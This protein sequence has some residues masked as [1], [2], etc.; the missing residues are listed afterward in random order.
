MQ[1]IRTRNSATARRVLGPSIAAAVLALAA[2]AFAQTD[3]M[4]PLPEL[5]SVGGPAV[6][7]PLDRAPMSSQDVQTLP[8]E[9]RS[10]PATSETTTTTVGEDGVETVTRTRRIT[11]SA[12]EQAG[13]TQYQT[14]EQS[15]YGYA[16]VQYAPVQYAPIAYAPAPA[17][18]DRASWL[19]ECR[20]RTEGLSRKERAGVIGGLIGAIGGGI[21]GNRIAGGNRLA[22]TLIGAG[23]GGLA[24]VATGNAVADG[25][26]RD[27]YDCEDVL[28]GYLAQPSAIPVQAAPARIASRTIPAPGY[29]YQGYAPPAYASAYSYAPAH[30]YGY[31]QPPQTVLVPVQTMQQQRVIVRET[32]R[33]EMVPAARS[34]PRPVAEPFPVRQVAPSPKMIKN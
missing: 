12:P 13:P 18:F 6:V 27:R 33:E 30:S 20:R 14:G 23:V 4:P 29:A 3:E 22:G 1:P 28:E 8:P 25:R 21:I 31:V 17:V 5:P 19:A 32:V 24:G 26:D 16:P 9:Y 2:P 7:Q 34:I 15:T 11:A 10:L